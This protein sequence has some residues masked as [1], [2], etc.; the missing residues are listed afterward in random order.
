M[1]TRLSGGAAAPDVVTVNKGH[2][3]IEQRE[4]WAVPTGDLEV[5]LEQAYGWPAVKWCGRIR[6]ARRPSDQA[7]WENVEEHTWIFG[8]RNVAATPQLIACWLRGYWTIENGV[9]R[10]LDVSYGEDRSHARVVGIALS[11]IR[12]AAINLIRALGYRYIPDGWREISARPDY[13]LAFVVS[14]PP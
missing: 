9:F 14:P 10:V 11:K 3:R 4:L 12:H 1:G 2:G 7:E 13:G 8:S 6:R 5:Y